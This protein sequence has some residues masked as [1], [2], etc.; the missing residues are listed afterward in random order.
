MIRKLICWLFGCRS[1][2]LFRY[3][4][5]ADRN[6]HNNSE[7]S[8]TTGWECERCGTTRTEQWDT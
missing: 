7:G 2:C 1:I 8:E 5:G 4:W 3:H 6:Y